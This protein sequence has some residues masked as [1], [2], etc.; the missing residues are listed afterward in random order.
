M[1]RFLGISAFLELF[2]P[3]CPWQWE[4]GCWITSIMGLFRR[5]VL[6]SCWCYQ[7]FNS[8]ECAWLMVFRCYGNCLYIWLS[9]LKLPSVCCMIFLKFSNKSHNMKALI[10]ILSHSW[11]PFFLLTYLY[12]ENEL[13]LGPCVSFWGIFIRKNSPRLPFSFGMRKFYRIVFLWYYEIW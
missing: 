4:Y 5:I 2:L 10:I 13:L 11:S 8:S 7:G 3:I 9:T 6:H 1:G 12:A